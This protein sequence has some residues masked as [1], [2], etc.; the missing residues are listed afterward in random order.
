MI[1]LKTNILL[2]AA[3]VI[4]LAAPA[5]ALVL[6]ETDFGS[7][8]TWPPV[9]LPVSSTET[10]LIN[11]FGYES[12]ETFD[13]TITAS[14]SPVTVE[15]LDPPAGGSAW[16]AISSGL[17]SATYDIFSAQVPYVST[18]VPDLPPGSYTFSF[19]D[20]DP[21]NYRFSIGIPEPA[22]LSLL[23]LG[24]LALIQRKRNR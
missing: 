19:N 13:F 4:C 18:A 6:N 1:S 2:A 22:T 14:A 11:G 9:T 8:D 20:G 12:T 17:D 16:V 24:G 3:L 21:V 10:T 7:F 15:V 5:N 23:A